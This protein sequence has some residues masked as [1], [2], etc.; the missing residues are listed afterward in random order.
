[1]K[2]VALKI[3]AAQTPFQKGDFS[4]EWI[5]TLLSV[6]CELRAK[7]GTCTAVSVNGTLDEAK[8]CT[9]TLEYTHLQQM[10]HINSR[11]C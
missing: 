2:V 4:L 7:F 1:M 5:Y 8:M 3:A 10:S 6:S 9:F 11:L